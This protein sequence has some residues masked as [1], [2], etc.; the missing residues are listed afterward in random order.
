MLV[1]SL[2]KTPSQS[3]SGPPPAPPAFAARKNNFA[4]P[5][6]RS[7]APP[8]PVR[9]PEPEP[10]VEGEWAEALYDYDSNVHFLTLHLFYQSIDLVFR[11]LKTFRYGKTNGCWLQPGLQTIGNLPVVRYCECSSN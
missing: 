7:P 11:I 5:P 3:T 2:K 6:G 9:Q 10:E 8:P 1:S 4:P